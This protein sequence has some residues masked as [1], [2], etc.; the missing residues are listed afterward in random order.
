MLT[1][2]NPVYAKFGGCSLLEIRANLARKVASFRAL[3]FVFVATDSRRRASL[4]ALAYASADESWLVRART[5]YAKNAYL[6]RL[7][8]PLGHVWTAFF[9]LVMSRSAVR[10]RSSALQN[11]L[12]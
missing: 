9:L 12:R 6:C 2:D 10:V 7:L 5:G 1:S 8:D 4:R 3:P 11:R